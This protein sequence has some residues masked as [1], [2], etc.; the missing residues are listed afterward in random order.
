M[1]IAFEASTACCIGLPE[2]DLRDK[3]AIMHTVVPALLKLADIRCGGM[4]ITYGVAFPHNSYVNSIAIVC[5]DVRAS[6][7][8]RRPIFDDRTNLRIIRELIGL[9]RHHAKL[10]HA[11]LS[12]ADNAE[13]A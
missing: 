2:H 6:G 8:M 3:A 9:N 12:H 5:D 7:V 11:T 10:P 1:A 13:S 4:K